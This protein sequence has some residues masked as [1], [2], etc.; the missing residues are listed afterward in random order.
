MQKLKFH[1]LNRKAKGKPTAIVLVKSIS[2]KEFRYGIGKSIHPELWNFK[3]QRPI[4]V[5][6][7]SSNEEKNEVRKV[8]KEFEKLDP[9]LKA[10]LENINLRIHKVESL[11]IS[12][13]SNKEA[14]NEIP[15]MD[16]L[17]EYLNENV[18]EVSTGET[19]KGKDFTL[20]SSYYDHFLK[21]IE[22][23]K[24]LISQGKKRGQKYNFGTIKSYKGSYNQ[25]LE[26]EKQY[27]KRIRWYDIDIQF[28]EDFVRFFNEKKYSRNTTGRHIKNLKVIMDHAYNAGIHEN[29]TYKKKQ[30]ETLKSETTEV[31]LTNAELQ[32]LYELDLSKSKNLER[33]RDVFLIGCYT[34]LRFSDVKRIQPKNIKNDRLHIFTQK[35]GEKIVIPIRPELKSILNKYDNKVPRVYEQKVNYYIKEICESIGMKDPI[36][37]KKLEGGVEKIKTVPKYKMIKTHTGRRTGATLLYLDNV[38]TI[39]IMK[40]TG[41]TTES[42]LLKYIRATP[43]E[44]ANRLETSRFFQGNI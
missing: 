17:R 39:D 8:L 34:A 30:F 23:G 32:K 25:F 22:E 7:F 11:F 26:F 31:Y 18:K 13:M 20:V 43:E 21:G 29:Q 38:P 40:I 12:Y 19:K 14:N 5:K 1:L 10:N 37:V 33:I 3:T 24:I 44:V 2:G 36:E 4:S 35:T 9:H 16:E 41:H 27:Q 6:D 42:N 28:Y 15:S